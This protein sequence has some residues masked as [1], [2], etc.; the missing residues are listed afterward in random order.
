MLRPSTKCHVYRLQVHF[1][2]LFVVCA[3]VWQRVASLCVECG[4]PHHVSVRGRNHIRAI[5]GDGG[6]PTARLQDFNTAHH[7][8]LL[9]RWTLSD[10]LYKT[11]AKQFS[12][13]LTLC[14]RFSLDC[15]LTSCGNVFLQMLTF[16]AFLSLLSSPLLL[17]SFTENSGHDNDTETGPEP[18]SGCSSLSLLS[19]V[20]TVP[21]F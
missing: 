15:T 14:L 7:R 3:G 6:L 13:G 10:D 18:T 4:V 9:A 1:I 20:H 17:L 21:P 16:P 5:P 2:L 8:C 19:C 11:A 12:T